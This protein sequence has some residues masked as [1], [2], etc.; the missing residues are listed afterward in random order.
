MALLS[1]TCTYAIRASLYVAAAEAASPGFV[2]TRRIAEDLGVSFPFLTKVLLGLTQSGVLVS[3]R[4]AAGGVA[5]ARP[6]ERISLLE[7]VASVG[8]DDVF[9]SCVLGLPTCSEEEPC[10]LHHRWK[11]ERSRLE[12]LFYGTSLASFPP[13]AAGVPGMFPPGTASS[14]R[15]VPPKRKDP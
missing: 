2:S 3:Q 8:G 14:I 13:V 15:R 4:G 10:A 7:I 5:L 6:A 12:A 9:R 11:E 1:T